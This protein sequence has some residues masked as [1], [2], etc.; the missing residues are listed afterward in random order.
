MREKIE[1]ALKFRKDELTRVSGLTDKGG[2]GLKKAIAVTRLE[3][4]IEL[5]ESLL[6]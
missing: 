5:L 2:A 6:K 4:E 1:A 3:I